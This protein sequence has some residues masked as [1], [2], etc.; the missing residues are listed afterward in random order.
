MD[1]VKKSYTE[2]DLL[3]NVFE[4]S[5]YGSTLDLKSDTVVYNTV[6]LSR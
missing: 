5:P 1:Y 3:E 6:Q 2:T 4:S